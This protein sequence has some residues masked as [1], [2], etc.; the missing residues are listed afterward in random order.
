MSSSTAAVDMK[1]S[2]DYLITGVKHELNK[3]SY[4]VVCTGSKL[5]TLNS[6]IYSTGISGNFRKRTGNV[7]I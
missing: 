2:G 6:N 3:E 1:K 5:A 4:N 7:P